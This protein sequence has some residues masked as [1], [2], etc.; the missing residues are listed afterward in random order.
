MDDH[1]A[2][3]NA[4]VRAREAKQR[5]AEQAAAK[6]VPT[7]QERADAAARH[8]REAI[9][10]A[11]DRVFSEYGREVPKPFTDESPLSFRRRIVEELLP[12]SRHAGRT[13]SKTI[14]SASLDRIEIETYADALRNRW[15]PSD[16]AP[17]Q[18]REVVKIDAQKRQVHEFVSG[19][20]S[21]GLFAQVYGHC[22]PQSMAVGVANNGV[23]EKIKPWMG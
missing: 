4:N 12:E 2:A 17:G 10:A 11:A 16:L 18:M 1:I 22:L 19:K 21:R 14:D 23:F 5:R 13:I 20:G 9:R 15:T 8:E 3:L 7:A 6:A